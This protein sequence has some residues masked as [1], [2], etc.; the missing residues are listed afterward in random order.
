LVTGQFS[1]PRTTPLTAVERPLLTFWDA[2]APAD[3]APAT[4]VSPNDSDRSG[5]P[6]APGGR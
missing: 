5:P 1:L 3:A 6:E 4:K 2:S